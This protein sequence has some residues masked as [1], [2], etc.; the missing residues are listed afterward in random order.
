MNPTKKLLTWYMVRA[1]LMLGALAFKVDKTGWEKLA[2]EVQGLYVEKDGEYVLDVDGVEDTTNLKTA[3]QKERKSASDADKLYKD[4]LKRFDGIDPEKVREM[5]MALEN[6]ED[7]KLIAKGQIDKVVERRVDQMRKGFEKQ[8]ADAGKVLD[9]EKASKQKYMQRVLDNSIRAAATKAGLHPHAVDDA[10]FRARDLFTLS[11]DGDAVQL[12]A[13][14]HPKVGKDGKTPYSP[15]EWLESMKETAPH[16]YPANSNGSGSR[17][18]GGAGG[19]KKFI[20]RVDFEKL[21][22][23]AQQSAAKEVREGKTT[24]AD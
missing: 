6:D 15:V 4:L 18:D 16:W 2:K 19:G 23:V 3:L 13:T 9:T 7:A 10:L 1:G 14:G 5:M 11:E 20:K 12:D 24:I 8:L 21:D 22:P 17:G